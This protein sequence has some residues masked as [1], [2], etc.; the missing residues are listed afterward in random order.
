MFKLSAKHVLN[1]GYVTLLEVTE[2]FFLCLSRTAQRFEILRQNF[3]MPS[4]ES[5]SHA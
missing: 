2:N 4:T 1:T 3:E 5:R